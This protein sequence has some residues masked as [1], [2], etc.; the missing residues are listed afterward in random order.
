VTAPE[1]DLSLQG[2]QN[3]RWR[4]ALRFGATGL[5]NTL[6]GY[7]IFAAC[8]MLGSGSTIAL[9]TATILGVAFNFQ[10]ARRLV[11]Q[12]PGR[13]A[14]FVAVYLIVVIV[15]WLLLRELSGAG[16]T[17]LGA[18]AILTIPMAAVAFIGQ[19]LLVF[20]TLK[21]EAENAA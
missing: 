19:R 3:Q 16:M 5:L 20:N 7:V 21:S 11:F 12:V 4:L 14:R 8:V 15:N 10:T 17:N 9:M 2:K 18:Q 13:P 6:V 1:H